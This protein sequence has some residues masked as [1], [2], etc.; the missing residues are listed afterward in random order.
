MHAGHPGRHRAIWSSLAAS[1]AIVVV[2]EL[3]LRGFIA[4]ADWGSALLM[5]LYLVPSALPVALPIGS[6]FSPPSAV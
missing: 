5:M 2:L 1:A 6:I 4:A 3:P